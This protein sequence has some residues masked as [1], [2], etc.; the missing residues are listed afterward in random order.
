MEKRVLL[1]GID[2]HNRKG[3]DNLLSG[4]NCHKIDFGFPQ[5][6]GETRAYS[7]A[8]IIEGTAPAIDLIRTYGAVNVYEGPVDVEGRTE[9]ER[10]VIQLWNALCTPA[11][12]ATAS[13][14]TQYGAALTIS[15]PS[16]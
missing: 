1:L 13:T 16:P 6:T 11:P 5:P 14:A 3:L 8:Y 7:R 15:P 12:R 4:A 2:E 9:A 10:V